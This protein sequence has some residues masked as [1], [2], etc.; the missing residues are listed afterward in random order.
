MFGSNVEPEMTNTNVLLESTLTELSDS[1][2]ASIS[3]SEA[4]VKYFNLGFNNTLILMFFFPVFST[5]NYVFIFC[6]S[7]GCVFK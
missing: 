7:S 3:Y 2:L 4:R 5:R 6:C 1:Q